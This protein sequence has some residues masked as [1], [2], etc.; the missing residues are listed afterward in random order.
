LIAGVKSVRGVDFLPI[1]Q[2]AKENRNVT[3]G[4]EEDLEATVKL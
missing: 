1:F 4:P 2:G 3:Q